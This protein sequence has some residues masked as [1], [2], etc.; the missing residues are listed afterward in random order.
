MDWDKSALE[1][2]LN[3]AGLNDYSIEENRFNIQTI[4]TRRKHLNKVKRF[5][6]MFDFDYFIVNDYIMILI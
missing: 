6:K 4:T 1:K 3:K 2:R 5:C